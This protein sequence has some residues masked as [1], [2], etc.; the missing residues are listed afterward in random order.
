MLPG[1]SA[2]DAYLGDYG[3]TYNYPNPMKAVNP[4]ITGA[5]GADWNFQHEYDVRQSAPA[6]IGLMEYYPYIAG[7][8]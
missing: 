5:N 3:S 2:T 6:D 4:A 7:P 1:T 8:F